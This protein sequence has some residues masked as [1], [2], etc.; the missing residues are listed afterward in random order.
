MRER[1]GRVFTGSS[2]NVQ[3]EHSATPGGASHSHQEARGAP[4]PAL[5]S[6]RTGPSQCSLRQ[7]LFYKKSLKTKCHYDRQGRNL[8]LAIHPAEPDSSPRPLPPLAGFLWKPLN[9]QASWFPHLLD[10]EIIPTLP[11]SLI[12]HTHTDTHRRT[13][14]CTQRMENRGIKLASH[15]QDPASTDGFTWLI[16]YLKLRRM[17]IKKYRSLFF[18]EN[19]EDLDLLDLSSHQLEVSN[20]P[21]LA[22]LQPPPEKSP[23]TEAWVGLSALCQ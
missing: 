9:L 1:K 4:A 11:P 20:E 8:H 23:L 19:P 22:C 13:R 6:G 12:S 16:Q 15:S 7:V 21:L 2:V 14:T 18:L 3:T 17:H 5:P 10:E